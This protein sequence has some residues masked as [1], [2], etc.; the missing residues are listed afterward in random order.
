M[1]NFQKSQT[2]I[3]YSQEIESLNS[4]FVFKNNFIVIK[5]VAK[6]HISKIKLTK[7]SEMK[8]NV[9]TF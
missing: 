1:I 8:K 2:K 3:L 5:Y 9:L 7:V 4:I 6:G